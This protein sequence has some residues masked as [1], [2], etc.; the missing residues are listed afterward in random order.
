MIDVIVK[1]LI[2][3]A[4]SGVKQVGSQMVVDAYKS[5]KERVVRRVPSVRKYLEKLESQDLSE[6]EIEKLREE[7]RAR[8][9]EGA[10]ERDSE[11]IRL[12]SQLENWK[13]QGK[14]ISIFYSGSAQQN[15]FMMVQALPSNENSCF[16]QRE[17]GWIEDVGSRLDKYDERV[18]FLLGNSIKVVSS[19]HSEPF[20]SRKLV[21]SLLEVGVP[22]DVALQVL[23]S[24]VNDIESRFAEK[25]EITTADIRKMVFRALNLLDVTKYPISQLRAWSDN[26]ARRYGNPYER[27]KIIFD[28]GRL[29]Y[30]DFDFVKR[31][32]IPDLVSFIREELLGHLDGHLPQTGSW[33]QVMGKDVEIM[34]KEIVEQ[35][36][37]LNLYEIQYETVFL[38]T[39][40]MAT[41]PP[42]PWFVRKP[43]DLEEIAYDLERAEDHCKEVRRLL[44]IGQC[45][46]P[47]FRH[48]AVECLHH[49]SSAVLGFYGMFLGAGPLR[50]FYKLLNWISVLR[51]KDPFLWE[52]TP[53]HQIEGDL[54]AIGVPIEEFAIL[55][56]RVRSL[57]SAKGEEKEKEFGEKTW[58]LY[59]I[60]RR[61]IQQ[62]HGLR[63]HPLCGESVY[64]DKNALIEF[65]EVVEQLLYSLPKGR[66]QRVGDVLIIKHQWQDVLGQWGNRIIVGIANVFYDIDKF[67]Q[68][69]KR[70]Q[71]KSRGTYRLGIIFWKGQSTEII[72]HEDG[73]IFVFC[74]EDLCII[75]RSASRIQ[76]LAELIDNKIVND[77]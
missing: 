76:T 39:L 21:K 7:I 16:S 34:A 14:P 56:D 32:L 4:L 41:Q 47:E 25:K 11:V 33:V 1:A 55:M 19:G 28:D 61:A 24:V 44:E 64:E 53:L 73:V 10:V 6:K 36:R 72:S 31:R 46:T 43:F 8:L 77:V 52:Q 63:S 65:K 42:H 12:A 62:H 48:A 17:K 60:L 26:Y 67:V 23:D 35:I 18:A 66:V 29:E 51:E 30:L 22:L 69:I 45:Y 13:V 71:R 20:K 50:P 5:L 15:Y 37:R 68:H 75:L 54:R 3:G 27:V 40:E 9:E 58:R 59:S 2:W 74:K 38:L 70:A 57:L 49:I